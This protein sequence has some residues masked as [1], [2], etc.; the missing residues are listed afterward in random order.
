MATLSPIETL[1]VDYM[2]AKPHA[3]NDELASYVRQQV[4]TAQT[5]PA[6]VASIKSRLKWKRNNPQFETNFTPT[7]IFDKTKLASSSL[8]DVTDPEETIQQA[9]TRILKRY[10][11]LERLTRKLVAFKMPSLIVSGPPGM[12]KSN[13]ARTQLYEKFPDGPKAPDTY[14]EE[15]GETSIGSLNYDI[16]TG[17]VSA[18]GLYQALWYTRNHGV[19]VLDDADAVLRD[20]DALNILKGALDSHSKRWINWRKEARWLQ[21]YGIP[22]RFEYNGHVMFLTNLDFEQMIEANNKLSE[23]MRALMDRSQYLCLTLRSK[24]DFM[25]RII[26]VAPAILGPMGIDEAGQTD[27]IEFIRENTGRFYT[28]SLRLVNQIGLCYAADPDDWKADVEVTKM[29]SL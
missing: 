26:Q 9:E 16:I 11:A 29:R 28:L 5:T 2:E 18:V 19:L 23:H 24:Q 6:S 13:E 15:T 20:E 12:G 7:A 4:P 8:P 10:S 25:I 14:D 27:I 21:D 3:T 22:D 17:S 1:I